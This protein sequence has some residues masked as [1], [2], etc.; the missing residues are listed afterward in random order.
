MDLYISSGI[1]PIVPE[2]GDDHHRLQMVNN[3]IIRNVIQM[4]FTFDWEW[5]N[6]VNL[7]KLPF[8]VSWTGFLD[9][10]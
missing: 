2:W 7:A 8:I 1:H 5:L 9:V 3:F 6:V 10:Y 4:Q